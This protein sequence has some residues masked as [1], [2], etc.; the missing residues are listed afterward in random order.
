MEAENNEFGGGVSNNI[1]NNLVGNSENQTKPENKAEKLTPEKSTNDNT[2]EKA[3]KTEKRALKPLISSAWYDKNY[4]WLLLIWVV[5]S[6]FVFGQLIYMYVTTGDVMH[7]DVSLTGGTVITVYSTQQINVNDLTSVLTKEIGPIFV[8][9][10][11]DITTGK[12]TA[13]SVETK[14]DANVTTSALE[15][16]LGY[17][18]T[19]EN[20]T[21]QI[22]G[23]E[24]GQSF[25]KQ[26]VFA[27]ILAFLLM[28][29]TVFIIFKV[30]IPSL[31]VIQCGIIDTLGALV[32]ANLF[33]IRMSSAGIAALLML[34]GYSVDTDILLTTRVLK[35][36]GENKINARIQSAFKTGITITLT[37]LITTL[38]GYFIVS[39][40]VLKQIFFVLSAGLV[41]DSVGTWIGNAAII[42]WYCEK[43]NID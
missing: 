31:A 41:F 10:I 5:I 37:A 16:Y 42:K 34:A 28:G 21:T 33:G 8:N 12:H 39:A 18:L 40:P 36:R 35:R 1:N 22:S 4:K 7:K 17:N 13:F 15:G 6:L 20:S 29:I 2:K 3:E 23:S 30:P 27:L 26:L 19:S 24:L 32:V 14:A 9:Q 25:Y 11:E 43:K 38:T